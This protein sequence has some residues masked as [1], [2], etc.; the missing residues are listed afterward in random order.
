MGIRRYMCCVREKKAEELLCMEA[1]GIYSHP[2]ARRLAFSA[3]RHQTHQQ[4]KAERTVHG[5]P[6]TR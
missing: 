6:K 2:G 1:V 5:H 3:S 4:E